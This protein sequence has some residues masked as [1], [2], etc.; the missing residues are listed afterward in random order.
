MECEII[1]RFDTVTESFPCILRQNGSYKNKHWFALDLEISAA[2]S[3]I[4]SLDSIVINT[5]KTSI[6]VKSVAGGT[7]EIITSNVASQAALDFIFKCVTHPISPTNSRRCIARIVVPLESGY[8]VRADILLLRL[9]DC[10]SVEQ[11]TDFAQPEQKLI[12]FR[13]TSDPFIALTQAV[14]SS[15]GGMILSNATQAHGENSLR[16]L[17]DELDRRL[18]FPWLTVHPRSR[19]TL[20]LVEGGRS[21]PDRPGITTS[22]YLTAQAL[23][24]EIVV[25]DNPGHWIE[26]P[27]HANWRKAFV[28][29]NMEPTPDFP[30][31]IAKAIRDYGGQ[32]DGL[33]T[34][35][36]MY[37]V[38]IAKAAQE[39]SLG[40]APPSAFEIATD[41]YRTSVFEGHQAF[42]ASSVA[43]AQSI[44]KRESFDYP[45]IVKP[46]NGWSS[47]G[48][49]KVQNSVELLDAVRAIDSERHGND[50]VIEKYCDGPEV[51]ANFI[52]LDGEVLFF[53][54]SDE[55]PKGA[56]LD[57]NTL[58]NVPG[59]FKELANVS[60]SGLPQAELAVLQDSL[61]QT[62]LRLGI[63]SGFYH[64]EA[65]VQDSTMGYEISDTH[66]SFFDLVVRNKPSNSTPSAWLIEINPRPPGISTS[67]ATKTTYGIDYWG[68]AMLSALGE[69]ESIRSLSI[70]FETASGSQYWCV[71]L[72]IPTEVGGVFDSGDVCADLT[73]RFPN[74]SEHISNSGCFLR[75]GDEVPSLE[76]GLNPL[77]AY[78]TIFSRTSRHHALELAQTIR[79]N[80][81]FSIV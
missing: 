65:R 79:E 34:F 77:V 43:E 78:F 30:H 49:T 26:G 36:D 46:C 48:V 35:C 4:Q 64:L 9:A 68:I 8:P 23:N 6:Y 60:P 31:R 16:L 76:S 21:T 18:S 38:A 19:K 63:R 2:K 62:L 37:M 54:V 73:Q 55:V 28:P 11:I 47:E 10:A 20:A 50:F 5:G 22:I 45:M 33:I 41:K 17:D 12:G 39:L 7:R 42:R 15:L 25:L 59:N 27:E 66:S 80:V 51:D 14:T 56:E 29:I 32:V 67:N 44:S 74:L 24:I 81:R 3:E 40:T 57:G 71:S 58:K 1:V 61:H 13:S 72:Y 69:E 70:P 53:E 52:L 75:K